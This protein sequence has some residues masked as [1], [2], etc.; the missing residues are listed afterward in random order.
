MCQFKMKLRWRD[1]RVTFHNLKNE[2]Y[3]NTIGKDDVD[4]I[5]LPNIVFY[6]TK[7]REEAQVEYISDVCTINMLMPPF[8]RMMPS[9]P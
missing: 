7:D 4:K 9:P 5:W 1:P 8:C 2:T 3:L 6:N